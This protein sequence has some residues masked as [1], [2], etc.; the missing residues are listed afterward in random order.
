MNIENSGLTNDTNRA[1]VNLMDIKDALING[2]L[3]KTQI[4]KK[5]NVSIKFI[6]NKCEATVNPDKKMM[7]QTNPN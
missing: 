3:G 4:Y 2:N 5:C 1:E 7:V 6:G